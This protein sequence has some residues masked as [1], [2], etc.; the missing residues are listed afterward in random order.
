MRPRFPGR[1]DFA[2]ECSFELKP[3]PCWERLPPE[4]RQRLVLGLV[5]EIERETR[6]CLEV[7]NRSPMGARRILRQNPHD[8]P[9]KTKRSP[10]PLVHAATWDEWIGFKKEWEDFR[11]RYRGAAERLG[12]GVL[13]VVFP[14]GSIPPPLPVSWV[15]TSVP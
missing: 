9:K 14:R 5:Q 7:E 4:E 11:Y 2:E 3:L 13:D 6:E 10:A 12:K 8:R 15:R 1:W